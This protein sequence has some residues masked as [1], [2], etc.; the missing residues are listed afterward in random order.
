MAVAMYAS[1][2]SWGVGREHGHGTNSCGFYRM[3]HVRLESS[4]L[5]RYTAVLKLLLF[6]I[7]LK[8]CLVGF[9]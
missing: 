6:E 7:V 3:R 5:T 9:S 2:W 4:I 8:S 1:E